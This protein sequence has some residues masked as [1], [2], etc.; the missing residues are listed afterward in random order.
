VGGD[1]LVLPLTTDDVNVCGQMDR[2]GGQLPVFTEIKGFIAPYQIR[3]YQK[4]KNIY[5]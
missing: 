3:I 5:I 1:K 4:K 2:I